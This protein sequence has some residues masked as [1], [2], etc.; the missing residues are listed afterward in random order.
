MELLRKENRVYLNVFIVLCLIVSSSVGLASNA[1]GI[2]YSYVSDDLN[3][4]RGSYIIHNTIGY[5]MLAI[6]AVWVPKIMNSNNFKL[7]IFGGSVL[8]GVGTMAMALCNKLYE[9]YILGFIRGCGNAFFALVV[10][11]III[12]NWYKKDRGF[13]TSIIFAFSGISGAVFSPILISVIEKFGWRIGY[14]TMGLLFI[15]LVLPLLFSNMTFKPEEM[16][17]SPYGEEAIKEKEN[18]E[19]INKV[20]FKLFIYIAIFSA[21]AHLGGVFIQHLTPFTR[22]LGYPIWVISAVASASNVGNV[23]SKFIAGKV[24]DIKGAHISSLIFLFVTIVGAILLHLSLGSFGMILGGLL[25][26]ASMSQTAVGLTLITGEYLGDNNYAKYY[27]I[28]AL[29][30]NTCYAVGGSIDGYIYDFSGSYD[31]V[32]YIS[33][34]FMLICMLCVILGKREAKK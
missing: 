24:S 3:I 10:V 9:F 18:I 30:G 26:G 14:V 34:G 8:T 29:I 33:I 7:L 16:G 11:S 19:T 31:L 6:V 32:V 28:F 4:L 12:N 23:I 15:V 22:H 25:F 17:M 21:S 5:L 20:S 27:P 2:F 13:I 1:V